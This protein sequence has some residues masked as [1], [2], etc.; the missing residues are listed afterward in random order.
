MR[1]S[2]EPGAVSASSAQVGRA[3]QTFAAM[4]HTVRTA[5][6]AASA[7]SGTAHAEAGL[8]EFAEHW[9]TVL[10]VLAAAGEVVSAQLEGAA[11]RYTAVD[12]DVAR[13]AGH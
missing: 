11:R 13:A 12:A 2:V 9:S 4:S 3:G 1:V 8:S 10:R 5:G 6:A 7:A